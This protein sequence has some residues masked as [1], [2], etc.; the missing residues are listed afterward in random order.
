MRGT[1]GLIGLAM[2][3]VAKAASADTAMCVQTE[4][5]GH[6]ARDAGRLLEARTQFR[7][8]S[9]ATCPA[10]IRDACAEALVET[11]QRIPSIV[12]EAR[13]DEHR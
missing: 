12:V 3:F 9:A 1:I 6:L 10:E 4:D 5:R 2:T 7:S 13:D 11:E 8:C